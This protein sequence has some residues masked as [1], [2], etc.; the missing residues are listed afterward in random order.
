MELGAPAPSPAELRPPYSWNT[1]S[2]PL[3]AHALVLWTTRFALRFVLSRRETKIINFRTNHVVY[4]TRAYTL[5]DKFY[6]TPTAAALCH[7]SQLRAS[8]G[9]WR[10]I[11]ESAGSERSAA[12]QSSGPA[13]LVSRTG[14][15]AEGGRWGWWGG[16]RS[17]GGT[18]ALD[19]LCQ[20][21]EV[22]R[23]NQDRRSTNNF[24]VT[25]AN[26]WSE[27]GPDFVM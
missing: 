12:M 18:K 24:V 26:P 25:W 4:I 5:R 13:E 8:L 6:F 7:S 19:V 17:Y 16:G 14:E 3:R 20:C 11:F 23:P 1:V 21:H 2:L 22:K 9:D 10:L 15:A 27:L